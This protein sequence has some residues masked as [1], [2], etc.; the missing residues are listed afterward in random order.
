MKYIIFESPRL[1]ERSKT[2]RLKYRMKNKQ[3]YKEIKE[4]L[5]ETK[6]YIF[7]LSF[8]L[9]DIWRLKHLYAA[10]ILYIIDTSTD[11]AITVFWG[12]RGYSE[13]FGNGDSEK[14][15]VNIVGLFLT[16]MA[17]LIF[18]RIV[19]CI[20]IHNNNN[21]Y[22]GIYKSILQLFDLLIFLELYLS[23]FKRHKTKK[24]LLI[25]KMKALFE[26]APQSLLL[27]VHHY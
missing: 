7:S 15:N 22:G 13:Y 9:T 4:K 18:Y 1:H 20:V 17:L 2:K 27:F 6:L 10:V 19:S 12:Q 25:S 24:I 3:K 26:S 8:L 5:I 11:I 21:K 23:H 14:D 16:A